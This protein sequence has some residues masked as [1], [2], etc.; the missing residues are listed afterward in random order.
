MC[1]SE[2]G[3]KFLLDKDSCLNKAVKTYKVLNKEN[4]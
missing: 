1:T 2:I 4:S 3:I